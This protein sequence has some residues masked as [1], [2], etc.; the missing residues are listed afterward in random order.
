MGKS[1]QNKRNILNCP[2][3]MQVDHTVPLQ[4]DEPDFLQL[5]TLA[6]KTIEDLAEQQAMP[7]DFYMENLN[8]LK[9][10]LDK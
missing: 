7:N 8:I 10:R 9:D 3:N 4:A 2:E 1:N 6:V 5:I